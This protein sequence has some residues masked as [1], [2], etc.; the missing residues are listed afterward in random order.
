[1]ARCA[2]PSISPSSRCLPRRSPRCRSAPT[3]PTSPS[4]TGSAASF[5]AT[6]T[7]SSWPAGA[8]NHSPATSPRSSSTSAGCCRAL[9]GRHRD[10]RALRRPGRR[11][12]RLGTAVPAH[13]P[14]RLTGAQTVGRNPRRVGLFRPPRRGR[15]EP[16]RYAV[17]PAP[18]A[19]RGGVEPPDR[20][21]PDP[22]HAHDD[23]PG[24]RPRLVRTVR[25]CRPGRSRREAARRGIR[26]GEAHHA[27]G[28]AQA[29]G[30]CSGLRLPRAHL[31]AGRGVAAA[32]ALWRVE[33][34]APAHP[35]RRDRGLPHG[36]PTR[37][38]RR[39]RPARRPRR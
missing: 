39:V 31:R 28:E 32:G 4:G 19:P 10:R 37:A 8:P 11:T 18:R 6:A 5:C 2:S 7:T 15:R 25:G 30:G 17:R 27:Q 9:R 3:W 1:M 12:P 29:H 35:R 36:H 38:D 20:H 16:A 14:G 26:P 24:D 22:P 33:R 13:P 34:R 23:R 21:R